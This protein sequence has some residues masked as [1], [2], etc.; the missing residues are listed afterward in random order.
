MLVAVPAHGH[1]DAGL[2]RVLAAAVAQGA[3]DAIGHAQ[4]VLG[5]ADAVHEHAQLVVGDV[6]DDV[7]GAHGIRQAARHV[8]HDVATVAVETVDAHA[9]HREEVVRRPLGP[10][11]GAVEAVQE[12][13]A[14]GKPRDRV[15]A[16]TARAQ[17]HG[18]LLSLE[19]DRAGRLFG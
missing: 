1:A 19:C 9:E 12:G 3:M 6:G 4:G 13:H 10:P 11:H 7:V 18:P 15:V 5:G 17:V 14:A 2:H 16:G 8:R